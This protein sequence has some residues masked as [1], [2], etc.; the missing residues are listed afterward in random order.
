ML[1]ILTAKQIKELDAYTIQQEPVASID[2]MERACRAFITWLAEK[3][4]SS[5]S[6]KI[7]CGTG[8]NGG[9]GLGIARVLYDRNYRVKVFIIRGGS[10]SEDFKV[11]FDRLPVKIERHEIVN[12]QDVVPF[13]DHDILI[14]AIFG[15]GLSRGVEGIYA[16]VIHAINQADV[17]R[18]AVDLPSGLMADHHVEGI[19]VKAH[20]TVSFQ[21]PKLAFFMPENQLYVGEW[22]SVNIGLNKEFI[23]SLEGSD[24][25]LEKSDSA[26]IRK[27]RT[28]FSHKG[29]YGKA[30]II[31]GSYGKIG[32]AVLAARATLRSGVGLL[33]VHVPRCGY[34]VLQTSVPEAMV[35]SDKHENHFTAAPDLDQYD[36]I[37]IGPGLGTDGETVKAFAFVL[38]H[39]TKPLVIDADG[40]NILAAHRELIHA[41][42]ANSILTPHP[43]E[44]ERLVGKWK[45]D[46][47]RLE[48]L[49]S[50]SKQTNSIIVLKGA[51]TSVASPDG[52]VSFNPTGNP[53][54]A[55]GGSGD[56]L[57]GVLTGLLAQHYT[58]LEAARLG[59]YV[60]GYAGDLAAKKKSMEAMIASDI[61][62]LL[63]KAFL[64]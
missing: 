54:M 34:A 36:A 20:Y 48:K 16:S 57:T 39:S 51:Y 45:N 28:K 11:N 41:L 19:V 42:P 4:D 49:R 14:D 21:L 56:V 44:F 27:Q 22:H 25:L 13:A 52:N 64:G 10:E 9:D 1:K 38:R 26:A 18:I 55:T 59:V 33:T 8:N 46:F 37:G 6:I 62:N 31:A 3:F 60:H 35:S 53:G 58:P 61:I 24:F 2:L 15:S 32:A 17:I 40:L 23:A 43:K 12:E 7:V 50:F 30:M 5:K 29:T 47:D 63:P